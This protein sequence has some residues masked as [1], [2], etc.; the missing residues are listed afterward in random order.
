MTAHLRGMI[1]GGMLKGDPA[2]IGHM[3]WSA[4]HGAI[5]LQLAGMLEPPFDAERLSGEIMRTLWLGLH[6]EPA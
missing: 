2:L 4:M 5:Q 6:A 1:D 3:F